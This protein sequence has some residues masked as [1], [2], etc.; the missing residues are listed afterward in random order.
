MKRRLLTL[1][2]ILIVSVLAFSA[3]DKFFEQI[4][5]EEYNVTF[6]TNGGNAMEATKVARDGLLTRPEDPTRGYDIFDGWFADA[7][8]TDPWDFEKDK[9][10]SDITLYAKW[11][12]HVHTG[13]TATCTDKPTCSVCGVQYGS[14][15]GHTVARDAAVAPTCTST[16]L[17][18]GAHCDVCGIVLKAQETVP[19]TSHTPVTV[20]AVEATCTSTGLTAG[21]KCSVCHTTLVEQTETPVK[22]HSYDDEHDADCNVCGFERDVACQHTETI[23][24]P[25]KAATC[26]TAGLTDGE[27]CSNDKC[28]AIVTEQQVIPA[29]G[30]TWG[31]WEVTVEPT[32]ET[33][34]LKTRTCSICGETETEVIDMLVPSE[35]ETLTIYYYT[36]EWTNVNLYAWIVDPVS[37][38]WPGT[39]MTAVEGQ[40]GWYTVTL[41]LDT[42][43]GLNIIFNNGT[44]QTANLVYGGLTYWVGHN[45]YAT[46]AEADEAIANQTPV[47]PEKTQ[48]YVRGDMNDWNTSTP[49]VYDDNG[50]ASVTLNLAEGVNFKV[51][52]ANWS[53]NNSYRYSAELGA[54]FKE[55]RENG[56]IEVVVGG[57]YKITVTADG[58]LTIESVHVCEYTE[59]V[60]TAA[61][62]TTPGVKTFTCE[63][64]DTYTEAIPVDT[65]AHNYVGVVTT[66]PTCTEEGVETYTC[67]HNAEHTYTE[68]VAKLGHTDED[69]N[70]YCDRCKTN[71]CTDHVWANATCEAPKTC[72]NCG[73]V[74][75]E[76]LGHTPAEAVKENEVSATCTEDGSYDLVVYCSVCLTH[77]ISKE[78]VTVEATGHEYGEWEVYEE[79][80]TSVEY[81]RECECGH[82]ESKTSV[83]VTLYYYTTEWTEVKLHAW[84]DSGD[85]TGAWPGVSLTAVEE[86]NGLF[87]ITLELETVEGLK[88]LFN[89]GNGHQTSDLTYNGL[90]YW[91]NSK[92]YETLED[93]ITNYQPP[94]PVVVYLVPNDNWNQA[95]AR[96][97]V[98]LFGNGDTWV[99]MTEVGNTGVYTAELPHGYT[100][101]I[102]CRMNPG[103]TANNWDNKWNQT[104]DLVIPTDDKICYTVA[105]GA[106]DYGNGSWD[107]YV[108]HECKYTASVTA[109][110]CT[111]AGYTTYTC[112]CGD[113]Y[114]ADEVAAL[115]HD[116]IAHDAK[117]ATCEEAGWNAYVTCSRCDY[118]TYVEIE[119]LGHD[120]V[121]H[122]AKDATCEE[123]GW[124][125]YVT[126]SRCDYSTYVEIEAL[127]HDEV[128]HDAKDATCEEAGWNAYA[129]CSRCDYTT[130]VE[131]KALGHNLVDVE[132]KDATCTEPGYT[133]YKDCSR[134]D[135]IEGKTELEALSHSYKSEVTTHATCEGDGVMTYTCENDATHTYTEKIPA[136]GHDW[137]DGVVTTDPTCTADGVKTYTCKNDEAHTY[138]EK[139]DALKHVDEDNNN[140]C[141]RE[142]CKQSLCQ[143]G[144]HI[145]GEGVVTTPATCVSTGVMTYTCTACGT[146]R[147]EVIEIDKDNHTIVEHDAK[148]PTC[149]EVGWN[150]YETCK[151]CSYS[152]Y[153]EIPAN[154]HSYV[155]HKAKAPT[156]TEIG[157]DA[158]ETCSECDYTTYEEIK[159]NGHS[160]VD[161][162][163]KAP[164]CTDIGWDAYVT[165]SECDYTTYNEIKA[166]GHSYVEHEAK[167]PTCTEIGWGAYLTCKNCNYSTYEEISANDHSYV[168]HDAKA[169]T[170]EEVGYGA[171]ETCENC[172]YSTYEEIPA[173]GHTF[174][175]W[176]VSGEGTKTRECIIDGCE[177]TE[178]GTYDVNGTYYTPGKIYIDAYTNSWGYADARFAVY[179]WNANGNAWFN[180]EKTDKEG[181]YSVT[182]PAEYTHVSFCRMNGA[183]TTNDWSNVWNQSNDIV[184][185]NDNV[186]TFTG[187][188]WNPKS[189]FNGSV[190]THECVY[191]AANCEDPMTCVLCGATK[192][193]AL[194]HI[195]TSVVTDPTCEAAGYTTHTCSVCEHSYTS[196]EVEALEHTHTT[197]TSNNDATCAQDG[198]K[199]SVCDVCGKDAITVTD[200]GTALD[201][202]EVVDEAVKATCT[203]D[204]KT[205][206][207]HCSECNTVIVKQ[208]VVKASGHEWNDGVVTTAPTCGGTG[209]KT[210]TC[211]A[212]NETDTE[213]LSAL[214]HID[215]IGNDHHCDRCG[216]NL[217]TDHVWVNATCTT[218]KTCENCGIVEGEALGHTPANAVQEKV[219]PATCT[220][221]G[222]YESV[223]Y[224][225]VEGCRVELSRTTET[226][227]KLGHNEVS[228]DAKAPTCEEAGWDAYV[229]C[230]RCD[231]TT[232]SETSSIGHDWNEGV[233]TTPATH[234]AKGTITYTCE[235]GCEKS[236]T[237]SIPYTATVYFKNVDDAYTK[238]YFYSWIKKNNTDVKYSGEWPGTL[239]TPVE[240]EHGWYSYTITSN[241][242]LSGLKVIFNN[243]S[244]SQTADL[245]YSSTAQYWLNNTSYSSMDA[246][247]ALY[248]RGTMNGWGTEQKA[249]KNSDGSFTITADLEK[250]AKFKLGNADWKIAYGYDNLKSKTDFN[251]DTDRNV[252]IKTAG[253]YT[254]TVTANGKLDV[255][256]HNYKSEITT[257][258]TCMTEGVKT[259]TCSCG[260]SY[261][262]V[263]GIDASAHAWNEGVETKAPTCG[264][265]GTMTFNC[266]HNTEHTYTED[267]EKLAHTEVFDEAKAPT[268]TETGLTAGKHC[269]ACDEVLVEQEEIAAS[270]HS[271]T[272]YVSNGD[273]TCTE[274]G[275]KTAK[276]DRCNET[277]TVVDEGSKLGHSYTKVV[278]A[279]TCTTDGYT[280]YTCTRGDHTYVADKTA[281]LGHTNGAVV[282]E[283]EKAPTC[284][285]T[286]S[287]DNVVYC[288]VCKVEVSRETI[289]V[290]AL[291][292]TDGETVV[293]NEK[294][295]TCT[296]TGSYDNVVYCTV[297]NVEL[298]RKTVEVPAKGHRFGGLVVHSASCTEDGYIEITCN[299]C[300]VTFTSG[301]DAEANE[302]LANSPWI[303][304]TA[305]GHTEVVDKAVA[306]TCTETGLTEGKHC[307]V[308]GEVLVKQTV[309]PALGHTDGAVVVENEVAPTCEATGSYDNVVYCT[310]CKV[311]VS[312]KTITVDA[313]G[314][315]YVEYNY[316]VVDGAVKYVSLC[317]NDH[318][319]VDAKD[320]D[321]TEVIPVGDDALIQAALEIGYSVYLTGDIA[322]SSSL[323]IEGYVVTIDLNGHTLTADWESDV[324]EVIWARGEGTKVTI[325]GNG[326]MI[327]GKRSETNSVV[328]A[329]DKA[330]VTINGGYYYS[331][332]FG[333]VIYA[334]RSGVVEILGGK[335]EAAEAYYGVWYVLDIN[336]AEDVLGDINVYG[337]EFVNYDPANCR[338]DGA[339]T[340]KVSASCHSLKNGSSYVVSEHTYNDNDYYCD[341]C[342]ANRCT[343]SYNAVV[344]APT[345]TAEGY[346]THT[347]SLC[348]HSYVDSHVDATG[349][350]YKAVVTAPTCEEQGYT[351]H[352][353]ANGCGSSYIN[354]Y[355]DAL[356]HNYTA[357]YGVVGGELKLVYTCQN[358]NSHVYYGEKVSEG[359]VVSV[360]NEADLKTVLTSGYSVVLESNIA[361]SSNIHLT[362]A[363]NV[364]IDLNG[365]TI[366]AAWNNEAGVVDVLWAKGTGVVVTITG[367]GTMTCTGNGNST[368]V[369]SA[370]DGAKVVIENGK[371]TS[372]GSACIYATRGGVVEILGG[373]FSADEEYLG[374]RYLLDVNEA[375]EL[376]TITVKGGIF[377][378][379]DP[380]NHT[381]DGASNTNKVAD[382]Y[383]SIG[384]N[385]V[386]TVSAHSY[387]TVVTAPTCVDKGYT[388]HTC[389]CGDSYVDTYVDELSHNDSDNDHKCNNCGTTLTECTDVEPADHMCDICGNKISYCEDTNNDH[390][391]ELCGKTL[392]VCRDVE[393]PDHKCDL[394][395]KTLSECADVKPAD[396]ECDV[397]GDTLTECEDVEPWDHECDVC[398][399]TL[400]ECE[401][402]NKNHKCDTCND[403]MSQCTDADKNHFCDWCGAQNSHCMDVVLPD[404]KCDWCGETIS[405][406]EDN[407]KDHKCD[408]CGKT[409]SICRDEE[410][411]DHKCDLCGK[412]LS[413]CADVDSDHECDICFK[414]LSDCIDTNNNHKCDICNATVSKC[415]D[416]DKNHSCDICGIQTSHCINI[417]PTEDHTCDWCGATLSTCEDTNKDHVCD[418]GCNKVFGE[419]IDTDKNHTCDYGCSETIGACEDNDLDHDCD[420]G[421]DKVYGEH[422]AAENSHNCGYCNVK[423][424][425]CSGGTATCY[426]YAVCEVCGNEYGE[427]KAHTFGEWMVT[428]EGTKA[429]ECTIDGCECTE[430]ANL[431]DTT[432][433]L[434]PNNNWKADG[435][436]FALYTWNN[437]GNAWVKMEDTNNDG[438][439]ECKLPAGYENSTTIIFCRM[440]RDK[441]V[442]DWGSKW[443]QTVN[444]DLSSNKAHTLFTIKEGD[445]NNANGSWSVGPHDHVYNAATCEAPMTCVLCGATKGDANGHDYTSVVTAPTCEDAGYTTYTCHCGHSY[446][447]D[448]VDALGHDMSDFVTTTAPSCTAEGV[449]R[450]DCSRC[451]YFETNV[452]EV[453]EHTH[454]TFTPNPDATCTSDGTM[455]SICDVCKGDAITVTNVGS[456]L[457]HTKVVDAAIEAT[458]TETGLAEGSHCSRCDKVLVAQEIVP[459][460]GHTEVVDAAVAPSCNKTG[461]TEGKHCS[462]CGE[463]LVAQGEV[464]MVDH[465]YDDIYDATCNVCG[466]V[467][468]AAC[469][470]TETEVVSGH[471]ATCTEAGLTDGSKCKKCGETVVAQEVIKALGHTEVVDKAVEATCTTT[472]L[473]AGKHCSACNEVLVAQTE[474]PMASHTEETVPGKAPTCTETGLTE[475]KKCSVC[476]EVIVVQTTIEALDHKWNDGVITTAPTCEGTG[477]MTYTCQ[478]DG[479]HT[480]AETVNATG[481]S[482]GDATYSWSSDNTTCTATRVCSNNS[483]HEETVNATISSTTINATCAADGSTT[484]T[485]TF[486]KDWATTQT[487]TVVIEATVSF[488]P[489]NKWKEANARFAAYFFINNS[490]S[491]W[492]DMTDNNGDGIYECVIPTGYEGKNVIFC[493][494]DPAKTANDWNNKWN[495]TVDL[496]LTSTQKVYKIVADTWS[497]GYWDSNSDTIYLDATSWGYSDA[498]YAIW[499]WNNDNDGVWV[500]MS[501]P[502]KDGVYEIKKSSLK[503]NL[504]FV[505][506][507]G[508]KPTNSW[509]NKW[510]QTG[511]LTLGSSNFFKVTSWNNQTSGWTTKS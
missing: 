401:D 212:C 200:V 63:C 91:S 72:E 298:S 495:Q 34:G 416:N 332:S 269:S 209:V 326:S 78:T 66:A 268:C 428:G 374:N 242:S 102:F 164:T 442:L 57:T 192:G 417:N 265:V 229:T 414:S 345:C 387:K 94:K 325:N 226:L 294:A 507:N 180:M 469:A 377:H 56:N 283:N 454:T 307:S 502:D 320:V 68:V 30:H 483:S 12:N 451:D 455:T 118:S 337:G 163:A 365:K 45:G 491:T 479:K 487:K 278:T 458:C 233:V 478:N 172:N 505:R 274:D 141:D 291:G 215:E 273:A 449:E 352:T 220:E 506:M 240:G 353:C 440:N 235:N 19:T 282:V 199:T 148:A 234:T 249:T 404:H 98:Y 508:S 396:H 376:G 96:F 3:C 446:I 181:I 7:D 437:S 177:G 38:P 62:C 116:E 182:I 5:P 492:V 410:T 430:K 101:L 175:D 435:A 380:A 474:I 496:T 138:E 259:F 128:A 105:E 196:D 423:M 154:G 29:L 395:G 383:H 222:S 71:L 227:D 159:A 103:T 52:T 267:I 304:I 84:G 166:N 266:E 263:I 368:C 350:D 144:N 24:V 48:W 228:H 143:P 379:F 405:V 436:W 390:R 58:K 147:T 397:C 122:D 198:T 280:T 165:C 292:H 290:D 174:G 509:D 486:D 217:C 248:L 335:F 297:C 37:A 14:P 349:H 75:G 445:W 153:N 382:G 262:E 399:D 219:V 398:G 363:M 311:E 50:N 6:E 134:C 370:T 221:G 476:D 77:V 461:L 236:Y 99:D 366:D 485:A 494:M 284:T 459:A 490:T 381:N 140:V 46:K 130:Y 106:W 152:T 64:S 391:C 432:I 61:T 369:V 158:Y 489:N 460:K 444:I 169:P 55:G 202:S 191:T 406:C 300:N 65:T 309:V 498:R 188:W 421:C 136:I 123:A 471:A 137:N 504:I 44:D 264:A 33:T 176:M 415:R 499:T 27:V 434:V 42:V 207:K 438:I 317:E 277:D 334:T 126:C 115:G 85:L 225:S 456:A 203:T 183:S 386:Y 109:P 201:H 213:V 310:V 342:S 41:E 403:V 473:T 185:G 407:N 488:K 321:K 256:R 338:N 97:A 36:T 231:Y 125:A 218:P 79:T 208:E 87:S 112:S 340:N 129:T 113:S 107:V 211:K 463:V 511:N 26:E 475:G 224:C 295:A 339:D 237:E 359:T 179:V 354:T 155:E 357:T 23:V 15:K 497:T 501:D 178:D 393:T 285:A 472:G 133:A 355:V 76:A 341:G 239:A 120:E 117:D 328:S 232:K 408:T 373:E 162:D 389:V 450:S 358:D 186:Y 257:P 323:L 210:Y 452:L 481:H 344:T 254:I 439:Y 49:L 95:D 21:S 429:R 425:E 205:E 246:A 170:C 394:C 272:N 470:H 306:P 171:Y 356:N 468:D 142:D 146:T 385:G 197:Y 388:T 2:I 230:S 195:Y 43:E 281:A 411:P 1:L 448:N 243:G 255:H 190:H 400:T 313:L 484:Y 206:G 318:N 276:C 32:Y 59:E 288:T 160:Y 139:V 104:N 367:N 74:E 8:F 251:V 308:C 422:A 245:V 287:Y 145:E 13:G 119:A 88:F 384:T 204:G 330:V 327:S 347:C 20:P 16:G 127:G 54:N 51:A 60:T 111:E 17:T 351:T 510:N 271:F 333:A 372:N 184:L 314:H 47:D 238:V 100:N 462:A 10:N 223:V 69:G 493:R 286:G 418:N 80:E 193:D 303:N 433:Y 167:A 93:A 331:E 457:G 241:N 121:A 83:K 168:K 322:L 477:T 443:D 22:A 315:N 312:R 293:E 70:S 4:P 402:A 301:V 25:G 28:G 375:E 156:C 348:Q 424:S 453:V 110:T 173:N 73:I 194:G 31:K 124:N 362:E 319:H 392:S 412:T 329:T 135:H 364:V 214:G 360:S 150:A 260:N 409:L 413:E 9:V 299:N 89:D 480:K 503:A 305:K 151:D 427:L 35:K 378:N 441:T 247:E 464:P 81:R 466:H 189:V 250:D 279:P 157:W 39:A 343:H 244:G 253:T 86:Q 261:T 426:A 92:G 270:G 275:T 419:H 324:C 316:A 161:H 114:V 467:R 420:Y 447:G 431:Y 18:E 53:D 11:T 258:A 82:Y 482:Y 302:Y 371:F 361:L 465:T 252:V 40:E 131:I 346:T 132:G 289:T 187:E 108:E 67:S 149:T 500:D 216:E 296:A 90:N 336:E